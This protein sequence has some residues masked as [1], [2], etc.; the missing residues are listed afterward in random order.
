MAKRVRALAKSRHTSANRILVDLIET[1][2]KSKEQERQEFLALV[3]RMQTTADPKERE[4]LRDI[5]ARSIFGC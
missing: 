1:G 3:E 4:D 2:L 5:V